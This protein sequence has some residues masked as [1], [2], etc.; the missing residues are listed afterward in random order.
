M[1]TAYCNVKQSIGSQPTAGTD[2]NV[3]SVY[4]HSSGAQ[5]R[6]ARP[7]WH[8][9]DR[10]RPGSIANVDSSCRAGADFTSRLSAAQIYLCSMPVVNSDLARQ[11]ASASAPRAAQSRSRMPSLHS[12]FATAP[13]SCAARNRI[14]CRTV[15]RAGRVVTRSPARPGSREPLFGSSP[16]HPSGL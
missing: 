14:D 5:R 13:S 2:Y 7:R 15:L 6:P 1:L 10:V 4:A 16:S 11:R 12:P 9:I 8:R 3:L